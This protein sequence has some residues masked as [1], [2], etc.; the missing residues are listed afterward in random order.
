MSAPETAKEFREWFKDSMSSEDI[1]TLLAMVGREDKYGSEWC[2]PRIWNWSIDHGLLQPGTH[3]GWIDRRGRWYGCVWGFHDV[4]I[5]EVLGRTVAEVE[6]EGWVRVGL[7]GRW[8]C[9]KT[10]NHS[11]NRTL[12]RVLPQA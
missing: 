5:H 9:L 1:D 7:E 6:R 2:I 11:Q 8:S 3:M 4:L 10:P 12:D